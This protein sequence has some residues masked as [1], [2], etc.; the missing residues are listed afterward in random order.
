[1]TTASAGGAAGARGVGQ[2]SLVF[3]WAASFLAAET[4]VPGLDLP[5]IV[6]QVGAQTG[7]ELD[8]IAILT[9]QQAYA[10]LQVKANL[11]LGT[12]AESPLGEALDQVVRQ[13]RTGR[14]PVPG[15]ARRPVRRGRDLLV[16]C[17]D[18]AAPQTVRVHLRNAVERTGRQPAGTPFGHNLNAK[19]QAALTVLLAHLRR[20]WTATGDPAPT[21]EQLRELISMLRV[22]TVDADPGG[23]Q[24]AA[25]LATLGTVVPPETAETAWAAVLT[26]HA[27]PDA[28]KRLWVN[29]AQ[30]AVA[31]H[32]AGASLQPAAR[33]A[34]D[35]QVLQG[36]SASN[37]QTLRSAAQLPIATGLHLPR[38]LAPD[39][40]AAAQQAGLLLLGA[41]G[42]GKTGLV[43]SLVEDLTDQQDVLLLTAADVA[44]TNRLALQHPLVDVLAAWT[45]DP[46]VLVIDGLDAL[47]GSE[48]RTFA[49]TVV[50]GL[51]GSRW[52]VVATVRTFDARHHAALRD[53]FAGDPVEP[54][55]GPVDPGLRQVRH[56][57]VGDLSDAELAPA[58]SASPE[59]A[60]FLSDADPKLQA[61]LRNPFNLR[62]AARLIADGGAGRAQLSTART[63]LD[64]LDAY[65]ER[66]V[67]TQDIGVRSA[68]LT[69]LCRH[70]LTA[71]A[72]RAREAEPLVTA[73][74]AN[75]VDGLLTENVLTVEVSTG[76]AG[77]RTLAFSH[78]ILFDYATAQYVLLDPLDPAAA[79]IG[80]LDRDPSL[81][82]IARPSLDM[83]IDRLW[84]HS[85]PEFWQLALTA[86]ASEHLL[87]TLTTAARL[88]ALI[89]DPAEL[90]ELADPLTAD[91]GDAAVADGAQALVRHLVGAFRAT[92]LPP[93]QS[94]RATRALAWLALQLAGRAASSGEFLHAALSIDLLTALEARLP[95]A[96]G[97][98]A[99]AVRAQA[100]ATLL[101]ACRLDPPGTEQV[102]R[103]A[104]RQ[105]AGAV[106]ADPAA[107]A[108]LARLLADQAAMAQWGG[109]VLTFLPDVAVALLPADQTLARQVALAVWTFHE[110]R[111]EDVHFG[112]GVLLPLRESRRQQAQHGLYRLGERFP[113]LCDADLIGAALIFCDIAATGLMPSNTTAAAPTTWPIQ[114]DQATGWLQYGHNLQTMGGHGAATK[115]A[116]ALGT[117]LAAA[118]R[119]GNDPT[120]AVAVLVEHLHHAPAWAAVL[121][122]A[123]DR[124]ALGRAVAPALASGTLL[125]HHDTREAAAHL[126]HA[127]GHADNPPPA[128]QL[129]AAITAAVQRCDPRS[130]PRLRDELLGCLPADALTEPALLTRRSE[131]DAAGGPPPITPSLRMTST[132][133][134]HSRINDMI[135]DGAQITGPVDTWHRL[136]T[137]LRRSRE[138]D[139]RS[140]D[141]PE[142][143]L[144][145]DAA[146]SG[147][148]TP[149]DR[150]RRIL[151]DAAAQLT[152]DE[153]VLPGTPAG[154][155]A[156]ALLLDAAQGG[157]VGRFQSGEPL[158]FSSGTVDTAAGGLAQLLRRPAWRDSAH[159]QVI[160]DTV[161][162]LLGHAEPLVR[163]RAAEG[164]RALH[165]ELTAAQ[166]VEALTSYLLSQSHP[167]IATLLV[168]ELGLDAAAAPAATDHALAQLAATDVGAGLRLDEPTA[169]AEPLEPLVVFLAVDAVSPFSRALVT[170]WFSDPITH[171]ETVTG[172][173]HWLRRYLNPADG[174]GQQ[175]AFALLQTA[176]QAAAD[177]WAASGPT[178]AE[179][180][181]ADLQAAARVADGIAEQLYFASGAFQSADAD[182]AS[183]AAGDRRTFA[184]LAIPVLRL[185]ASIPDPQITQHVAETLT[186]LAALDERSTLLLLAEAVPAIGPYA[187]DP[188]AGGVIVRYLQRL[189]AEHPELVVGDA[190]ALTAFRHLLQTFA[191]AGHEDALALCFG[192]SD[193]FR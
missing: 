47:R 163:M 170:G 132:V 89:T 124:E 82:L 144:A 37:L 109:T 193:I 115:M 58:L 130:A 131:L 60:A 49:V 7:F 119:D 105:L 138:R 134:P 141:L 85:R 84:H 18:A 161:R 121:G 176:A 51:A 146:L 98:P 80:E 21:D 69:R 57:L 16:L 52:R 106:T 19:E 133:E 10:L 110:Q 43:V 177:R 20:C 140:D 158:S 6:V 108:A 166:R 39:L 53:A 91:P 191:A 164:L 180:D 44:G 149:D 114:T 162:E 81:P 29:R 9:D 192:F 171:V 187:T 100:L 127:L 175:Q 101:D 30:L 181:T 24:H 36:R 96:A 22:L 26:V 42:S 188:L 88:L 93:A 4:T 167:A 128:A 28:E 76:L 34:H 95:L 151:L 160:A 86:A 41:P 112:G 189:V 23:A 184:E 50:N 15:A 77:P 118:V 165:A 102:A 68:L 113:Q 35:V 5:G 122:G 31:L 190:D 90:T 27:Q 45:G 172:L 67:L 139:G 104:V 56:L 74:D 62:L 117:A 2:Q 71:R 94:E 107:A 147:A 1:V 126:L 66:R 38:R 157:Q 40:Q 148:R 156:V 92:V 99:A 183:D 64:V 179:A 123:D 25:A 83:L 135:E 143:F 186:H 145:A 59:L 152:A 46:A 72:L 63:Q 150:L 97:A 11:K 142:A 155:R 75:A 8:D 185:C 70:M 173:L 136:E 154:E 182:Q 153:R 125:A 78:N 79:L 120:P 129:Q 168:G 55:A 169:L 178:P 48:D 174:H 33:Y 65:W 32:N 87:V 137:A 116:T 14:V 54:V 61:L 73:D 13:Y 103:F 3:A 159:H 17:T 111:D 12:T